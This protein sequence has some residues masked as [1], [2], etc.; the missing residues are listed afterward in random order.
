MQRLKTIYYT[1]NHDEAA[2]VSA[3][4]E[5]L[6]TSNFEDLCEY[7]DNY[8]RQVLIYLNQLTP[9][10]GG[11]SEFSMELLTFFVASPIPLYPSLEELEQRTAEMDL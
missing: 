3:E 8:S 9:F 11:L 4:H 6:L 7:S 1:R 5:V 2:R 10:H